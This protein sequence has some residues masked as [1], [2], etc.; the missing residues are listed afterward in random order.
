MEL[1]KLPGGSVIQSLM[2]QKK[3][4]G[5]RERRTDEKGESM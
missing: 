2:Q 1:D 4:K 5:E 3:R